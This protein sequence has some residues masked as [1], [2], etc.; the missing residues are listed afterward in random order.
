MPVYNYSPTQLEELGLNPTQF[1][2]HASDAGFMIRKTGSNEI[3]VEAID[4]LPCKFQY[5][6]T[7]IPIKE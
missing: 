2:G 1:C 7:D 3:Y 4:I 5:E 6:E